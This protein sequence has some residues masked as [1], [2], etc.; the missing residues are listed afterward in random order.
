MVHIIK[1]IYAILYKEGT[2]YEVYEHVAN[3]KYTSP[4]VPWI[5][6]DFTCLPTD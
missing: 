3:S 6:Y 1:H 4:N 2:A 5:F